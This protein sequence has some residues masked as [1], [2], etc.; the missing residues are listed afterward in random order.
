MGVKVPQFSFSRLKG[1]DPTLGIEMAS[2][3]EVA[4]FGRDKHEAFLH[5]YA[6]AGNTIPKKGV[7]ISL[8]DD[9][10]KHEFAQYAAKLE[11][12]GY[13]LYGTRKTCAILG[14]HGVSMLCINKLS[15]GEPHTISLIESGVID[16]VINTP[17]AQDRREKT[18]GFAIR[19][20][21]VDAGVTLINDIKLARALVNALEIH[22]ERG[23]MKAFEPRHH[24]EFLEGEQ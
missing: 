15:Q 9:E 11:K 19:R 13:R 12:M 5:A 16:L 4:S 3:G 23:G 14:E 1:A 18:D 24:K 17:N 10:E 21:A 2:T 20:K 8:G 7:L 22:K 6:S